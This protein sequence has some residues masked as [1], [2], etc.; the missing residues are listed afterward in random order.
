MDFFGASLT[1]SGT[2]GFLFGCGLPP[3][4]PAVTGRGE[5]LVGV[6]RGLPGASQAE[7]KSDVT[8]FCHVTFSLLSLPNRKKQH[9]FFIVCVFSWAGN[10]IQRGFL[11][12]PKSKILLAVSAYVSFCSH[13]TSPSSPHETSTKP[14]PPPLPS[15]AVEG[16]LTIMVGTCCCCTGVRAGDEDGEEPQPISRIPLPLQKER[17]RSELSPLSLSVGT[18]IPSF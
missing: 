18:S 11:S 15:A 1:C 16:I 7:K 10:P 17:A 6:G 12:Q 13:S 4:S 9:K 14:P 5:L 8:L 2:V 3:E